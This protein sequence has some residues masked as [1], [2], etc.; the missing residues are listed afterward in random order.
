MQKYLFLWLLALLPQIAGAR[1]L[2]KV[3]RLSPPYDSFKP[4][5]PVAVALSPTNQIF[6]L[7]AR[8]AVLTELTA[9][10][11]LVRQIG[12]PGSGLEQFSDPAD[13]CATSG[14]DLFVADRGNDRII[15]LDRELTY[16]A[17]FKSLEGT[18]HDL[19]FENPKSVLLGRQGDLYIADGSNDRILKIDPTGRPVFS[20]GEYGAISGSLLELCRLESD[21]RGGLWVLDLQSQVTRFDEY[22]GYIRQIRAETA[23]IPRGLAV[24]ENTVW[25]GSDSLLWAYNRE[26]RTAV[27]YK[28][29]TLQLS[30]DATLIDLAFRGGLL[31]LLDSKG[32]IH[33]YQVSMVQ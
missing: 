33:Q 16:L 29:E 21:P 31:W 19:S 8:L 22:G 13:V 26:E 20:F 3:S 30:A 28:T 14:L 11:K 10:G 17:E 9:D 15:R 12:G 2:E 27:Q 18:P 7:D 6:L 23:G 5:V 25:V 32:A 4:Q 24:T 1:Q